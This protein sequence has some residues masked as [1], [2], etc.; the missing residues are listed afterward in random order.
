[1][2]LLKDD[3]KKIGF[4][5]DSIFIITKDG[6]KKSMPLRWFPVLAKADKTELDNYT[7]S[8]YGIHWE[9]LNEDLSF[10]GFFTYDK[11]KIEEEK[12]EIQKLLGQLPFLNLEEVSRIAGI[13]PVLIRHYACGVKTPSKKR[14]KEI[15]KVLHHLGERLIAI[16]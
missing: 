6:V 9:A 16:D 11:D 2:E 5:K 13:N 14:T 10:S 12:S 15:K 7:L 1:M 3:I 4:E 8:A